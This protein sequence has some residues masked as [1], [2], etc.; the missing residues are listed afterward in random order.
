MFKQKKNRI[1]IILSAGLLTIFMKKN[2][3]DVKNFFSILLF[4]DFYDK[5]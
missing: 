2:S 3:L 1:F 5:I 4:E